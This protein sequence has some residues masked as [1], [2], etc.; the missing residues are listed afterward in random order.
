MN[1]ILRA[2]MISSCLVAFATSAGVIAQ[3]TAVPPS[4]GASAPGQKME[5]RPFSRPTERVE[6]RLA[7]IKTALKINERQQSVWDA[8]AGE[9]RKNAQEMEKRFES[10]RSAMRGAEPGSSGRGPAAGPEHGGRGERPNANE[11]LE[12]MQSFHADAVVRLNR[13]LEVQKPLYAA[14]SPEQQ[15]IADEV[16]APRGGPGRGGH[17][18]PGRG[19]PMGGAPMM[20]HGGFGRG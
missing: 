4:P 11:R 9:M 1:R 20:G 16:L 10:M 19:G 13:Q 8:Y 17:G 7:Y 2:A 5:R 14:L 6:A 18:G 3:T 15:R 12:R